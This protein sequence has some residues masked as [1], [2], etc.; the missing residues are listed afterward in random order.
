MDECQRNVKALTSKL[1]GTQRLLD[2][3]KQR[4]SNTEQLE[5]EK[6]EL[7]E[8]F[9]AANDNVEKLK[10]QLEQAGEKLM[11]S[12]EENISLKERESELRGSVS[13]IRELVESMKRRNAELEEE[14]DSLRGRSDALEE[15][16][17]AALEERDDAYARK[18]EISSERDAAI[19]EHENVKMKLDTLAAELE[20]DC[21]TMRSKVEIVTSENKRLED[22]IAILEA[23][24]TSFEYKSD[25]ILE[26]DNALAG[27]HE[28]LVSEALKQAKKMSDLK[29]EVKELSLVVKRLE[30]EKQHFIA[31]RATLRETIK[32]M[33]TRLRSSKNEPSPRASF[34]GPTNNK[35]DNKAKTTF[36]RSRQ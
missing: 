6:A 25:R 29:N 2:E 31:E 28:R 14:N 17:R 1:L 8:R 27:Q 23:G 30:L 4:G 35:S 21:E 24:K 32:T 11:R 7:A 12:Q 13:R 34:V 22:R 16:I 36:F 18:D 20:A 9:S 3:A 15:D 33:R 26:R 5:S 19:E 10:V